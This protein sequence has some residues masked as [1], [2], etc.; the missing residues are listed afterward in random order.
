MASG[1]LAPPAAHRLR[2]ALQVRFH[3]TRLLGRLTRFFGSFLL[4]IALWLALAPVVP[5][6]YLPMPSSVV[7]GI[8]D[9]L[10]IGVLPAYIG[11]SVRHLLLAGLVGIVVG[12]PLG[13]LIGLSRPVS[14][15]FYPL[16]NF[17]Q[18]LSGIAW[19]PMIIVWFGFNETSIIAAVNYT[20]LFPVIFN[21][22]TGVRT[23]PRIYSN[24]AQTLGANRWIVIR[25]VMIPGALPNIVTGIRLGFAYGWR[26][27]IAAEMLVGA[28]GLGF[29]IF[30][31]QAQGETPQIVAGMLFIGT[32]WLMLD[33]LWLRP[34]EVATIQR[35][36]LVGR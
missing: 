27:M 8:V 6:Y 9:S 31:A 23:V 14:A 1:S 25:D 22:M 36:G 18:A 3:R 21:T 11:D 34:F 35:W 26:A 24:A 32:L 30:N 16:L 29:M 19:M 33:Q 10:T 13:V 7:A 28:N 12:V 4:L 20:V 15:F 2:L 17:F 5:H